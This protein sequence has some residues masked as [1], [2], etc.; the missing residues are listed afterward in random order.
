M[1]YKSTI[2]DKICYFKSARS[3]PIH[4]VNIVGSRLTAVKVVFSDVVDQR[5]LIIFES[6]KKKYPQHQFD[7]HILYGG[8][9]QIKMN[10]VLVSPWENIV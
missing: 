1:S 8:A 9:R 10:E 3:Q 7:F 6:I 5:D 4:F 2:S